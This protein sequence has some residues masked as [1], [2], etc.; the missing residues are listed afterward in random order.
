[1]KHTLF[2][3]LALS[4]TTTLAV[5]HT[6]APIRPGTPGVVVQKPLP[7]AP[8]QL[9]APTAGAITGVNIANKAIAINGVSYR[10]GEPRVAVI[11]RR[12][13]TVGLLELTD[14]RPGMRVRYRLQP[15]ADKVQ[16]VVELWIESDPSPVDRKAG[17]P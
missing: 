9:N 12:P 6:P 10:I 8:T 1:M 5:A 14:L 3:A 17:K 11:D 16:R 7:A 2:A 4:L 13:N 15:D